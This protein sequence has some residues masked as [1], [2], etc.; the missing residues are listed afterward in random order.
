MPSQ[1]P[2]N[3]QHR[4]PTKYRRTIS[5]KHFVIVDRYM[6]AKINKMYDEKKREKKKQIEYFVLVSNFKLNYM[7]EILGGRY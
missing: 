7:Y 4:K 5:T 3:W 1:W 6:I 2:L